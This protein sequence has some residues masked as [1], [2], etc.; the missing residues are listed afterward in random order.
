MHDNTDNEVLTNASNDGSKCL[1]QLPINA[2]IKHIE[3]D[4][5]LIS[6]A[7]VTIALKL[8]EK[9][10]NPMKTVLVIGD[11]CNKQCSLD[12]L[13]VLHLLLGV[14]LSEFMSILVVHLL[15]EWE[16]LDVDNDL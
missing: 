9:L 12:F 1:L 14:P 16:L 11:L 2:I 8:N 5:G 7:N 15:V 10:L 3:Q 6:N 4:N 13:E